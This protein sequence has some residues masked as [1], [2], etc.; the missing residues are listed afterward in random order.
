MEYCNCQDNLDEIVSR[1]NMNLNSLFYAV[2]FLFGFKLDPPI[3]NV[4]NGQD[5]NRGSQQFQY[6]QAQKF[7]EYFNNFGKVEKPFGNP[8]D[9][10]RKF[11]ILA[12]SKSYSL[13]NTP[14]RSV[15][16]KMSQLLNE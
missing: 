9:E 10:Y 3:N 8:A 11:K 12:R 15:T 7:D 1:K 13:R 2:K 5:I 4:A 16:E 14:Y 6:L